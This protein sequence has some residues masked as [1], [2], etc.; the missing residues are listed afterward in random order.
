MKDVEMFS[1]NNSG[2]VDKALSTLTSSHLEVS[3]TQEIT[4][5]RDNDFSMPR[6]THKGLYQK[7]HCADELLSSLVS[8][9]LTLDKAKKPQKILEIIDADAELPRLVRK[10]TLT[11]M[12]PPKTGVPGF[13]DFPD[14]WS[15]Q[16]GWAVWRR[17]HRKKMLPIRRAVVNAAGTKKKKAHKRKQVLQKLKDKR[18]MMALRKSMKALQC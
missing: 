12:S 13:P 6:K 5:I 1:S 3:S 16:E 4:V 11:I 8:S 17:E 2:D 9:R 15:G 14:F 18:E 7:K 10:G